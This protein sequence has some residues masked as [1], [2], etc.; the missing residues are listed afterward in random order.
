MRK[1]IAAL[2]F[3]SSL[4]VGAQANATTVLPTLS[5]FQV[6]PTSSTN[7]AGSP[8]SPALPGLSTAIVETFDGRTT[9]AGTS[10]SFSTAF[11]SFS[12]NGVVRNGPIT[13]VAAP[14]L[15][16]PGP[17]GTSDPTNYLALKGT[18][19]ISFGSTL[20][21][22]FALYW[23]SVDTLQLDKFLEYSD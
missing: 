21:S 3:M 7:Y 15:F 16:G 11:A 14:P 2:G 4:L 13:N 10:G 8:F 22:A 18:E 17:V 9:P 20:H 6:L 23:G 12:G 5:M 1:T 19:T